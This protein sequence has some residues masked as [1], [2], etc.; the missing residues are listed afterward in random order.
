M[1]N[2]KEWLQVFV[3]SDHKVG[4][5]PGELIYALLLWT[6]SLRWSDRFWMGPLPVTAAWHQKPRLASIAS[7]PLRTCTEHT[8]QIISSDC[9]IVSVTCQYFASVCMA[10]MAATYERA[11]C[12]DKPWGPYQRTTPA[13]GVCYIMLRISE[14]VTEDIKAPYL[15][16]APVV[17]AE[18]QRVK[19]SD[20]KASLQ[21]HRPWFY[22]SA[23]HTTC[24]CPAY[25]ITCILCGAAGT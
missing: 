24:A 2:F 4:L 16:L 17:V 6:G 12:I 25:C 8:H 22:I 9:H 21:T 11:E 5:G 1:L 3:R 15:A 14:S 10:A 19:G 23:A 18:P 20:K 13:H 7:R